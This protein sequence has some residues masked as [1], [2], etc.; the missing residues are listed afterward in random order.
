MSRILQEAEVTL[1]TLADCIEDAGWDVE[2][3]A[4][5]LLLHTTR[6]LGFF[7]SIESDR[8]FISFHTF[9]RVKSEF[10]NGLD[11][12]NSLNSDVFLPSFSLDDDNDLI[13]R[14][15]MIYERGLVLAQFS[16]ILRR[17]GGVLE[18]VVDDFNQNNQVFSFEP[19][20]TESVA[21]ASSILQ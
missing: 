19:K 5:R 13:V 12:V 9:F 21:I 1:S 8:K 4:R 15:Q 20:E 3:Q 10:T 2:L 18:H 6:G 14:Y 17:F 11:L 16:R 7:I